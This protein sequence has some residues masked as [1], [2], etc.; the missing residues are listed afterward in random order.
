MRLLNRVPAC[1][2][3]IIDLL[4]SLAQAASLLPEKQ[5]VPVAGPRVT[6]PDL[7][8]TVKDGRVL[9]MAKQGSSLPIAECQALRS[10]PPGDTHGAMRCIA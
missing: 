5:P 7:L 4:A 2:F 1:G 10:L 9:R 8:P 6:S 3:L